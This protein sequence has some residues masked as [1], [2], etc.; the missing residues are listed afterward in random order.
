MKQI[1]CLIESLGSGGAERQLTGLA[2]MLKQQGYDVEVWYYVKNEFYLPYLQ[3]NGV[4]GRY[5]AGARNPQKR[6]FVLRKNIKLYNPNVIISYSASSSMISCL[7]KLLGAKYNLIVSERNT[8]QHLDLRERFKFFMYKWADFVV[9]NSQSQ[10]DFIFKSFSNLS[11]KV[12]VVTNYVDMDFFR[13]EGKIMCYQDVCHMVCVGRL[14]PQKNVLKFLD[15]IKRVKEEGG[16]LQ[17]DWYGN[18]DGVY[19][20]DCMEKVHRLGIDDMIVFKGAEKDI[21]NAYHSADV[22]CLPSLYEGFPNVICEAMSCGLPILCSKVC[23]NPYIV[24]DGLNGMMFN[25]TNEDDIVETI[26]NFL[27][28]SEEKRRIMGVESRKRALE[29]FSKERFISNYLTLI[30]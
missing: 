11:S 18:N 15:V 7:L 27:K 9:P 14:F 16:K 22:F 13:P 19:A 29:L 6:L 26:Y 24:V 2:V 8:T 12:H 25:P 21:R 23:D 28:L 4:D 17:I 1:V 3:D 10:A 30:E 5:L 20:R